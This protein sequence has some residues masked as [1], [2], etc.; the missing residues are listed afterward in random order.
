MDQ[1]IALKNNHL[2]QESEFQILQVISRN[3]AA[4][5]LYTGVG[6][7]QK[8]FMILLAARE[9]GIPP[10]QAMNGGIWN[11]QGKIE[12][13]AR[14]MSAM[15]R[16]AGHSINVKHSDSTKCIIEGKR[17]DNGDTF[18]AQ[19]TIEDAQRAGL[20]S[21]PVWK[22]YA[23]DLLY[24]R[25]MSRL[26][27]RLFADVIG[28]AYVEGEIRDAKCEIISTVVEEEKPEDPE[29]AEV[30]M[31]EFLNDYPDEEWELIRTY[32]YKYASHWKKGIIQSLNDYSDKEKFLNDFSKWKSKQSKAA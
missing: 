21:R 9:L 19:F 25:A 1:S 5:G 23:E 7:E 6:S 3:A 24:A 14:L 8:I 10:M 20:S 13:S 2:P 32:I 26:A 11:I 4:S 30:V 17:A 12:I 18:C 16:R 22:T 28:T 31:L 27:R 15:I 29:A